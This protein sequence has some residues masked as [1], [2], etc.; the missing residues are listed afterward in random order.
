MRLTP[1]Q[2]G[3]NDFRVINQG[4]RNVVQ[5]GGKDLQF[6]TLQDAQRYLYSPCE[7]G[8]GAPCCNTHYD[9]GHCCDPLSYGGGHVPSDRA[10][11]SRHWHNRGYYWW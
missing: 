2:V 5:Y 7:Y 8:Y 3:P 6:P 9:A 10:F 4:G 1:V 11:Q